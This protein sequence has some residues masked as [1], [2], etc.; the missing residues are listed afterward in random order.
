MF[1]DILKREQEIISQHFQE[2]YVLA[3]DENTQ[4]YLRATS[5]IE[6]SVRDWACAVLRK[7]LITNH[8]AE[9]Q[10]VTPYDVELALWEMINKKAGFKFVKSN[11]GSILFVNTKG[12]T[13]K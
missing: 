12:A 7:F 1:E 11:P 9:A 13:S 3:L 2:D 8:T 5:E 4:Q 6:Y 10:K